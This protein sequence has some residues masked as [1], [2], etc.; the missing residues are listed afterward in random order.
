[1]NDVQHLIALANFFL[2]MPSMF[3]CVCRLN[4]MD[5]DT[6][7]WRVQAEYALGAGALFFSAFSPLIGEWPGYASLL[8]A[9]YVLSM[10]LASG[11]AWKNDKPPEVATDHSPL[12][13]EP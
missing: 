4:A 6:V 13:E 1:M 11:H 2:C 12:S 10:L 5:S 9:A 3:I 7:L 8:T